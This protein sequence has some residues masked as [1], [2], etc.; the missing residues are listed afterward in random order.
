MKEGV[1]AELGES[2][3]ARMLRAPS[4][5]G[6]VFSYA[7]E[8]A[9]RPLPAFSP[10]EAAGANR[11]HEWRLRARVGEPIL[12]SYDVTDFTQER[13]VNDL[14]DKLAQWRAHHPLA[15]DP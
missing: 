14:L 1:Q 3:T 12:S 11:S 15:S 8:A 9:S 2:A 7:V 6:S 10:A 13:L 4:R 5:D